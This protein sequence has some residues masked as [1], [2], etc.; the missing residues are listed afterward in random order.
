MVGHAIEMMTRGH[1][2]RR[3]RQFSCLRQFTAQARK[4]QPKVG[5]ISAA[6]GL[7]GLFEDQRPCASNS[8]VPR[9]ANRCGN[10][11]SSALGA[12][13]SRTRRFRNSSSGNAIVEA[14]RRLETLAQRRRDRALNGPPLTTA[15]PA[16]AE[17]ELLV[18]RESTEIVA[19][20]LALFRQDLR[21][22]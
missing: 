14:M 1:N 3:I 13:S 8:V 5:R 15:Q 6:E 16:D 2:P 12:G 18:V 21:P 10:A 4:S 20:R 19:G 9:C 11:G 22:M 17:R 7:K